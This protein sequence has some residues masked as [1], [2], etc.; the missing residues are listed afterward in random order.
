MVER[1]TLLG[2]LA[3]ASLGAMA[4]P[5]NDP[6]RPPAFSAPANEERAEPGTAAKPRLQSVLISAA[7]K[8]AVINGQ[9][10]PLGARFG[11][12]TLV[13]VTET[14]AVLKHGKESETL[15][16]FPDSEKKIQDGAAPVQVDKK[17]GK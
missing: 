16:L 1:L 5:L 10:V 11:D 14:S 12:A 3:A 2:M 13:A 15:K 8:L 6:M 7:R 17:G 9:T 4:Q